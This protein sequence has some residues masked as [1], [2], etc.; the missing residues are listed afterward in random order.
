V[1]RAGDDV[2]T[3]DEG[4]EENKVVLPESLQMKEGLRGMAKLKVLQRYSGQMELIRKRRMEMWKKIENARRDSKTMPKMKMTLK[5]QP[6]PL[7]CSLQQAREEVDHLCVLESE[8]RRG[9]WMM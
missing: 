2:L 3:E 4:C 1:S 6:H 9:G 7:H 5:M 8:Q